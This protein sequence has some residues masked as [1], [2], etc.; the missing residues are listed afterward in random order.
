MPRG[1]GR[2]G[3]ATAD[4]HSAREEPV[5]PGVVPTPMPPSLDRSARR[6]SALLL[7]L[8]V[9]LILLAIMSQLVFGTKSD[10][11]VARNDIALTTM[12]LAIESSL[13]EVFDRLKTDGESGGSAAAAGS[14]PSDASGAS[15]PA[16]GDA[17]AAGA[18]AGGQQQSAVDSR[19]DS[20]GRPQRTTINQIELRI[21]VQDEDSK[22]NVL[23]MLASNEQE[24]ERCFERVQRTLDAFREGTDSD[25]DTSE[26]RTMA[27]AMRDHMKDRTHQVLPKPH[28]TSD[29]EKTPDVGLPLSLEE[30]AVLEPFD[31]SMF[32]DFREPDG[33][34][35]HSLSSFLTTWTSPTAGSTASGSGA[36]GSGSAGTTGGGSSND[37]SGAASGGSSNSGGAGASGGSGSASA[38]SSGGG[39][40]QS[41]SGG[42]SEQ[43]GSGAASGGQSGGAGSQSGA[44]SGGQGASQG[45]SSSKYGIAVNVNTAPAAVL[46]S[47]IDDREIS[48][49]FWDEVIEYRN[50]EKKDEEDAS[51]SSSSSSSTTKEPVYD[52]YGE[53]VIERQVFESLD[54]LRD[55]DGYANLDGAARAKLD[56]LLTTESQVFTIFVTARL[57]TGD[58]ARAEES[59]R[60]RDLREDLI[61][62]GLTRTV[63]CVVWRRKSGDSVTIVPLQ[64]WEVIDY[65]PL[66]VEDYPDDRR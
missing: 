41:S 35:V 49:R 40:A 63:R 58:E 6:G 50:L 10:A 18:A 26:A 62:N 42:G 65:V 3:G 23:G 33:R 25:I 56:Q 39:G 61:A 29:D 46:K 20:W 31:E 55:V 60:D 7:A 59:A 4:L 32:R 15:T 9:L 37:A 12:D 51:S 53:E 44:Q 45:G 52:E 30:F 17:A 48:G 43:S 8:L 36:A 22:L 28:L 34:V 21:F 2:G 57:H 24:A 38:A 64:R 13:L 11:D 16:A 14:T 27:E 19:E 66:A 47:L 54:N 5:A 1:P